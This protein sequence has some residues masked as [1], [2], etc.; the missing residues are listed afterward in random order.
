MIQSGIYYDFG[1]SFI[2]YENVADDNYAI[3]NIY[4][5]IIWI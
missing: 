1:Y 4:G 2:L 5:G 3:G